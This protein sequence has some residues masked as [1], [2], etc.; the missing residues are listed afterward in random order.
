MDASTYA[1]IYLV[2]EWG[3]RIAMI[4]VCLRRRRPS[5]AM[6]WLLVIFLVPP[7]GLVM[8][9]LIG[10][11]RLGHQRA[12][13]A[14]EAHE[15]VVRWGRD[16][17]LESPH[18]LEPKINPAQL[19]LVRVAELVG[20]SP[21]LGR[22]AMEVVSETD[23]VIDGIVRD[24]DG[25]QNHVNILMYI[26]AHDDTASKVTEALVRAAQRGLHVRLAVDGVGSRRFLKKAGSRLRREGVRVVEILPVNIVRLLFSRID[27]RNHRKIVVIDGHVAWTGSQN[28]V[29]A[30]YGQKRIGAWR[31]LMV[32]LEGPI[33]VPLQRVFMED[34]YADTGELLDAA[35][36]LPTPREAGTIPAQLVPSGPNRNSRDLQDLYLAAIQEAEE[37][38]VITSPYF[39]PDEPVMA[40]LR[41]AVMRGVQVDLI[42]PKKANHPLVQAAGRSYARELAKCGVRVHRHIDGLLHAKTITVDDAFALVGSSNFDVR[43]FDINFELNLIFYGDEPV[44]PLRELQERYIGESDLLTKKE[45]ASASE[46]RVLYEDAARLLSPLL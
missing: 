12:E 29:D 38:I 31:D 34:W 46:T 32:R 3:F 8:Y 6:A 23:G 27:I 30:N 7:V 9:I 39:V 40:A 28:I 13:R 2:L 4:P 43:S 37:R 21:I 18:V 41:V 45:A 11:D 33:V 15:A 22:N 42:I 35:E 25:A 19:D 20:K 26:Y 17:A 1:F 24:I 36:V 16:L 5:S 44:R 10:R 14:L